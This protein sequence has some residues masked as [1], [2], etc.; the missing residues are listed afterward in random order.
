[1]ENN[2]IDSENEVFNEESEEENN[3]LKFIAFGITIVYIVLF[4]IFY[5]FYE[6]WFVDHRFSVI[7]PVSLVIYF[8]LSID[9]YKDAFKS[10]FYEKE[11]F[12]ESTLIIVA[13]IAA[14]VVAYLPNSQMEFELSTIYEALIVNLLYLVGETFEDYAKDKSKK[15]IASLANLQSDDVTI[16]NEDGTT[17]L[18]N[19]DQVQLNETILYKVGEKV[20]LDLILSSKNATLNLQSLTGES[21]PVEK[22]SGDY[23]NSG[24]IVLNNN[25]YGK[26]AATLENSTITKVQELIK[27]AAKSKSKSEKIIDKFA[28]IYTPIIILVAIITVIIGGL[29]TKNWNSWIYAGCSLLVVSCPCSI[30][31]SVPL[32]QVVAIGRASKEGILVKGGNYLE[33][34]NHADTICFDKTGTITKGKLQVKEISLFGDLSE[35]K[36]LYYVKNM[37]KNSTHPLAKAIVEYTKNSAIPEL[38]LEIQEI[39]GIGLSY[40]DEEKN[41]YKLGSNKILKENID[42]PN[43]TSIYFVKN[44][45]LEAII[46]FEDTPKDNIKESLSEIKSS[47]IKNLYLISGDNSKIVENT[48]KTVGIDNYFA[49]L[50]PDQKVE[51]VSSLLNKD[52]KV[53]FVGDGINDAPSIAKADCGISM[54]FEGSDVAIETSDVVILNDDIS[55]I[56]FLKRISKSV[57]QVVTINIIASLLVKLTIIILSL[58]PGV[59]IPLIVAIFG[60]VGMLI[61]CII[62]ALSI[63]RIK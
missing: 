16:I 48:A 25:I 35:E 62:N 15:Q 7:L 10:L 54:G 13:S 6:P 24:A 39:P 56:S 1:M 57:K 60:D 9:I 37:E 53:I 18:K 3:L 55:K 40:Q 61:L 22:I 27:N 33:V 17:V 38:N 43:L 12:N 49:E 30:V 21:L 42:T 46:T 52:G 23:I 28:K 41:I 63:N 47:G 2:V 44:D 36:V 26:V 4:I 31:I 34:I 14:F 29:V 8:F 58:I 51:I 50:M 32:A 20:S 11:I 59:K 19:I 5:H 45:K